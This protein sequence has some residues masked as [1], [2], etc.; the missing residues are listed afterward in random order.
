MRRIEEA[1]LKLV[2]ASAWY[3]LVATAPFAFPLLCL[4]TLA[5]LRTT[6]AALGL[7]G[8]IPQFEPT[9][10]LFMNLMGSLV[11]VW[12]ALRL[13]RTRVE[14][15]IYD[16]AARFLFAFSQG[17]YLFTSNLSALLMPF[18]IV[19]C[20]FGLLQLFGFLLVKR[21]GGIGESVLIRVQ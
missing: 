11:L 10:L 17:Y 21:C 19:E 8:G 14:Y 1:Y 3:D 6:H 18:F 7:S 13:R 12:S 15:G 9:H 20:V 2:R 5:L 4:Q 16:A